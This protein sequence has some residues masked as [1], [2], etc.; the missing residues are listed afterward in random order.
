MYPED[1]RVQI[2]PNLVI[3]EVED[4]G[5]I[6]DMNGNVYFSLN[7]VALAMIKRLEDGETL[8]EVAEAIGEEFE[9]PVDH[10]RRDVEIFLEALIERGLAWVDS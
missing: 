1:T 7:P 2:K 9:A 8:G 10:I 5:L 3:E 4:E 6:L